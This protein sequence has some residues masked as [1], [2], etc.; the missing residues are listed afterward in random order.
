MAEPNLMIDWYLWF[1]ILTSSIFWSSLLFRFTLYPH[2]S[3]L[4]LV[5]LYNLCTIFHPCFNMYLKQNLG[6]FFTS[7]QKL[8]ICCNLMTAI[9]LFDKCISWVLQPFCL[10]YS[11]TRCLLLPCAHVAV[12]IITVKIMFTSSQGVCILLAMI[13]FWWSLVISFIFIKIQN[14]ATW[15]VPI[16]K[17]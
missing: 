12:H 10:D 15:L 6:C 17:L 2:F 3:S 1:W 14:A 9:V 7:Y 11:I 4:T 8:K 13:N 5:H 16:R